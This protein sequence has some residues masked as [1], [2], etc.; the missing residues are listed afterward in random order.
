MNNTILLIIAAICACTAAAIAQWNT[1]AALSLFGLGLLP[2][3]VVMV[4]I[5]CL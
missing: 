1:A 2:L 3:A 4:G 5:T